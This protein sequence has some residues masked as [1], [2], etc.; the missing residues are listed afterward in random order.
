MCQYC[1][2]T[3]STTLGLNDK[4][5]DV[6]AEW[7]D[8]ISNTA[9]VKLLNKEDGT[10]ITN[11]IREKSLPR[12]AEGIEITLCSTDMARKGMAER[13]NLSLD[14]P[15][16]KR[17]TPP[18][19]AAVRENNEPLHEQVEEMESNIFNNNKLKII[20]NIPNMSNLFE[21]EPE[22]DMKY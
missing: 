20:N 9:P 10:E 14:S 8:V 17:F 15:T 16:E 6:F 3:Y 4:A 2:A 11:A 21:N 5:I 1:E 19:P 12:Y 22:L 18:V 13:Y 7:I